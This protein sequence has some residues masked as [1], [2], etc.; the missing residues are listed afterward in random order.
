MITKYITVG[1]V[2][3]AFLLGC[4]VVEVGGNEDH[5]YFPLTEG[6]TWI[7][8]V[9]GS[10]G[11]DT[12][13]CELVKRD[14]GTFGWNS[15]FTGVAE[16]ESGSSIMLAD[17]GDST[18]PFDDTAKVASDSVLS[19]GGVGIIGRKAAR[20]YTIKTLAG[21]FEGC[22]LIEGEV[23]ADGVR[24]DVWLA[25]GVGPVR[26]RHWRLEDLIREFDLIKFA[27]AP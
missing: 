2:V 22:T 23:N 19:W 24:F 21:T 1:A 17:A 27:P 9:R 8:E 5:P 12:M 6:N 7:Y 11:A 18:E 16:N 10:E 20:S 25:P 3:L 14:N 15:R 4:S 13:V 26:V